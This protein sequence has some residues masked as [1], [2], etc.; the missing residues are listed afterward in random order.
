MK[1]MANL[2]T[3]FRESG[4]LRTLG[5]RPLVVLTAMQ[6]F[7][8]EARESIGLSVEEATTLQTNWEKLNKDAASWST[9]SR[10]QNVPD[11]MHYIQ[12]QRPDIVIQAINEV[13]IS[14]RDKT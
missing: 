4:E 3:T 13:V 5:D 10:Q 12:F 7:T 14:V 9:H 2:K 8:Q 1:E 11:S 6:P